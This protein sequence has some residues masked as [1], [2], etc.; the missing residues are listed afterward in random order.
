MMIN[1]NTPH[2]DVPPTQGQVSESSPAESA[3]EPSLGTSMMQE[4]L[5]KELDEVRDQ[6]LRAF[7]EMENIR[8]RSHKE[9]EEAQKFGVARFAR[10]LLG[11]ADNLKRA[12]ASVTNV[13]ALPEHIQALIQGVSMT[14]QEL[15]ASFERAHIQVV[16]ALYQ[17]FD[18][19]FHQAVMEIETSEHA[20]G[21]VIQV[22]QEGY[23]LH[24]RLLRPAMV[25]VAKATSQ[26][27]TPESPSS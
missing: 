4:E 11:V 27:L 8:K 2:D 10:E 15:F 5:Q 12:L 22:I 16:Q 3:T 14:E 1:T 21:T 26:V 7:A 6:L 25:G 20:P 13:E 18:P 17:K 19:A 24:D 23:V 9:R